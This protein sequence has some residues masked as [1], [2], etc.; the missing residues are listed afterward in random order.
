MWG[1]PWLQGMLINS[2]WQ[3]WARAP[4]YAWVGAGHQDTALSLSWGLSNEGDT[5]GSSSCK[6]IEGGASCWV[7]C[8]IQ[9]GIY[10]QGHC[11]NFSGVAGRPAHPLY[12]VIILWR[13]PRGSIFNLSFSNSVP[14]IKA[15]EHRKCGPHLK[16]VKNE[17][18][19]E[20]VCFFKDPKWL[21]RNMFIWGQRS[22]ATVF[23]FFNTLFIY[24]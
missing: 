5:D 3:K 15:R 11:L 21:D 17:K 20:A 24:F 12:T 18:A 13:T 14:I 6:R 23:F 4:G 8:E 7:L 9:F 22:Y 16:W 19:G 1:E 2:T 10:W